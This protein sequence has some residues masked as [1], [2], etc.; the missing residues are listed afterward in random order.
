M[1][2]KTCILP[3]VI[4]LIVIAIPAPVIG[5]NGDEYYFP[6]DANE[7][8]FNQLMLTIYVD[9][10]GKALI[11][12]YVDEITGLSFLK[13]PD[14]LYENDTHQLY[15][16]TNS[17]TSKEGDLW[18]LNFTATSFYTEYHTVL[19]LPR[20][21]QLGPIKCSTGLKPLTSVSN[22][23]LVIDIQ[24]YDV[25]S[26]VIT[27]EYQQPLKEDGGVN[28]ESSLRYVLPVIA[29]SSL[30]LVLII[31]FATKKR[32]KEGE[33]K[34]EEAGAGEE[35]AR[36]AEVTHPEKGEIEITSDMA[37]VIETLTERERAIVQALIKHHGEMTQ[38]DLRYETEIPKSSLT[39]ILRVLERRKIVKKKEWGRTNV[40]E[41][42]DWF[43]SKK[44]E[45]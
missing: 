1:M 42:S 9:E 2:S 19:Y 31:I 5:S 11:T 21:V 4:A 35:G 15:A 14:Y 33:G 36:R 39:G 32:K 20:A 13:T 8:Y 16:L 22:E 43:L 25:A 40:I 3:L 34:G 12:G 23:S 28:G 7:T 41:L 10:T 38:A 27:I 44:G 29:A 26:P 24:G 30:V 17:L 37:R 45:K 6:L 18:A